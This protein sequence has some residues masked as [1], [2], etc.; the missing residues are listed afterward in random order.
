MTIV[1]LRLQGL[2]TKAGS[3]DIRRF[4]HGL[5]IPEG[6][7]HITGGK[8]GEAFIIFN[9]EREGQLAMRYSGKLL[10]GSCISLY[11]SSLAELKRKM[12]LRLKKPKS[13]AV[14]TKRV[15]SSPPDT[16]RA[17]LLS[18]MTA[19]QG[20][21]SDEKVDQC[22]VPG[23]FN[24]NVPETNKWSSTDNQTIVDGQHGLTHD[25]ETKE[26]KSRENL[27][28]CKPGYLRLYGFP[29]SV[30]K[31]EIYQFLLGLPVLEVITKVRLQLGWCCLVKLTSF[32]D[33]EEGLKYSHR[34]F[35]EYNVAVRLAHEKMWT[36]AVEQSK[37]SVQNANPHTF[38]EQREVNA[39][40]NAIR[41]FAT[42]RSAEE[43]PS[44]GSPKKFCRNVL[45]PQTELCVIVNHLSKNIT[46]TE[47]K[48]IF[49]CYAIPNY[50]IKHLLN[51][52][53]ERTS[54]A[55]ITFEHEEDY[56]SAL[57]MNG[58]TVGLKNIEVSPIAKEEMLAILSRNR[59]TKARRPPPYGNSHF[60]MSCVYARNFRADVRKEEVRD[61]FMRFNVCEDAIV[62][63][64]DS[65]GNG[66]GEAIVQ[67]ACEEIAKQAQSLHGKY[68][69]GAKILLACI[70]P[71]QREKILGTW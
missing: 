17:L 68:F 38:S 51:K 60:A 21:H 47:I 33:A 58:T 23:N 7:V 30:P 34:K 57:K 63:L 18:L 19:I 20:L 53:A 31:E 41:G 69:M 5:H 27:N 28:S 45:S 6:G 62:L 61:F 56:A 46:K 54:T 39:E 3:E 11:I 16:N 55:F 12:E 42:K 2:N 36:D 24:Q 8:M 43:S 50:R 22:Q 59:C 14:E 9:S 32:A 26:Q 70:T 35:K 37:N 29:D 49:G 65:Q 25:M 10:R 44:P 4:F 64:V 1:V 13:T 71:Q 15:T 66:V 40:R 52:W 48:T 67:F